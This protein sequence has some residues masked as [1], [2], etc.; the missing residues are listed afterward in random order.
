MN[1]NLTFSELNVVL[2]IR[3]L[4]GINIKDRKMLENIFFSLKQIKDEGDENN[5]FITQQ[6]VAENIFYG[7]EESK[8]DSN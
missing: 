6:I 3:I 4:T 2:G 5:N 7:E 8:D 1:N